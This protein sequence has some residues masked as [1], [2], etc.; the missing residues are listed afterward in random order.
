MVSND[1]S[2]R[3]R[4]LAGLPLL[5]AVFVLSGQCALCQTATPAPP[6]GVLEGKVLDPTS[7]PIAGAR[8]SVN[9]KDGHAWP[10]VVTGLDGEF[11]IALPAGDYTVHILADGFEKKTQAVTLASGAA[12]PREFVLQ[13]ASRSESLTITDSAESAVP[14]TTTTATKT[15]TPLIDVPQSVTVISRQLMNDQLMMSIGDV[16][17]YVPGVTAHQGE[18]NRDQVVIR[19]NNSSADFFVDGVRDDVQYYRDLY[20]VDRVEVLKGPNA[21]IFGRGGGGGVINRV[22]K[23]AGYQPLREITLEGGSFS[24]KRFT[25]DF[26]QPFGDRLAFRLNGVYEN[27]D[28][29]RRFVNLERYGVNPTM[30]IV[31]GRDTEITVG[32]E[33]FQDYRRA[34]RGISSYM[35]FPADVP[36]STYYGNPDQSHVR[37][38]V[39]IGTVTVEHRRGRLNLHNRTL[40][41]GYDRGYQNFV[42]RAVTPDKTQV[43]LS[44]YNNATGRFNFFNQ[45]DVTYTASTGAIR[46][47]LLVGVEAGRQLTDNFRNTGYFDNSVTTI[48]L[49][50]G[51]PL[52]ST[53]ATFRQS[54]TDANNHIATNIGATYAQD[55]IELSRYVQVIAGLRFDRFNLNFFNNRTGDHLRRPD[56]LLSPRA[57]IV[58]KPAGAVSLY[59]SYSVSYLPSAG[60]QFASLTN[61]TQQ[62]KPEKFTNYETGVKWDAAR[63]LSL[64]TA[65]YQLNRTNTRSLDP[66]DPTRIVQTGSQRTN[67]FEIGANGSLTRSW[68]IAGGYA[69]QDAFVTSA[70]TAARA[71][72]QV[73]QVPHNS[74]SLW[75]NYRLNSRLGFGLGV[76]NR[77]DMFAAID[78]TVILPGYTR[79]DA[80][81][82]LSLTEKMRLQANVENLFDRRY[83]VNA[84]NNNNI[85]PGFPRAVRL[86]LVARF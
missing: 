40:F 86:A 21:M 10:A 60:D 33:H 84:D 65:V 48:L 82:F 62:V 19:G 24:N 11:S 27:S 28:S 51:D 69:Y 30:N 73:A 34:D 2:V 17:N 36:I 83:Y 38:L 35:G 7:T 59:G 22:I 50:Y 23:E 47:T 78:D 80:A 26:D 15:L 66:N 77:S 49:P 70:T 58:F 37:A 3:N 12:R 43:G 63:G 32:Y 46:H 57:G 4:G 54:P 41:G 56:N 9:S 14:T 18:N 20:N 68:T 53:P 1:C 71:G 5:A 45:T 74:F 6:A 25:A 75:N 64:T 61:I 79:A 52:L 31:A 44:A 29:F 72:A 13:L 76:L 67:G 81:V 8:V 85:S 55:Q 39:N 42:P 16:V